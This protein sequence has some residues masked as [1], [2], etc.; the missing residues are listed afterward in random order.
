M[1][2]GG[3]T[4]TYILQSL[5]FLNPGTLMERKRDVYIMCK[6][7]KFCT[8]SS[9]KSYQCKYSVSQVLKNRQNDNEEVGAL[10]REVINFPSIRGKFTSIHPDLRAEGIMRVEVRD[11][12]LHFVRFLPST[13]GSTREEARGDSIN[14][15]RGFDG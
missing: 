9:A 4:D 7:L 15:F 5:L 11:E 1:Q 13:D 14:S 3:S 2:Q 8:N 12:G 6:I 10:L